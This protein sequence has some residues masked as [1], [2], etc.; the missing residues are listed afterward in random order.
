MRISQGPAERNVDCAVTRENRAIVATASYAVL[1]GDFVYP[2]EVY[3][4][5]DVFSRSDVGIVHG[6]DD[7]AFADFSVGEAL[8]FERRVRTDKRIDGENEVRHVTFFCYPFREG[9]RAFE[10]DFFFGGPHKRDIAPLQIG[11]ERLRGFY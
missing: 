9:R 3:N 5:V 1:H 10:A 8:G 11:P 4:A 2:G 7:E 6:A